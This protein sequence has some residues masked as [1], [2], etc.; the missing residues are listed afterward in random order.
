MTKYSKRQNKK[1]TKEN[2]LEKSMEEI[3]HLVLKR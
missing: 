2:T 1:I 3:I